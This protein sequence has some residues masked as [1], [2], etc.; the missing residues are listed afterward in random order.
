MVSNEDIICKQLAS[1][2]TKREAFSAIVRLYS[3][4]LY[5]KIRYI[6]LCHDDAND[7]L[8]NTF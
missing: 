1:D 8:Q 7:V 4:R 5:W 2:A 6:V 3:E